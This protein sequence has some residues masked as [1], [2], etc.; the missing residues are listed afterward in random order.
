MTDNFVHDAE[1]YILEAQYGE[2][3]A[4]NDMEVDK[5]LIEFR[6]KNGGKSP[7]IL[8]VLVDDL[9]FGEMGIPEFN[10]VR[11]VKTP[12]I[13]KFADEGLSFMRM[14]TEPSCTPSRVAMMTGR[15]PV[16]NGLGE[17]KA[18]VAGEALATSEVTIAEVLS[19][20]GYNTG[21]IGKWHM[22]DIAEGYPHK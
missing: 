16:R 3:W 6:A 4:A 10:Y 7:N 1:Y 15:H 8:Y 18:T 5:K 11:G 19:K 13:N 22:G 9:S 14:Y 21:H 20:S 12:E 17:V 2:Q